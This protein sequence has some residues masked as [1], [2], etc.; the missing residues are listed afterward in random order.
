MGGQSLIQKKPT[1][2]TNGPPTTDSMLMT[3]SVSRQNTC[4]IFHSNN[5]KWLSLFVCLCVVRFQVWER[6]C[7]GGDRG[8]V[9][10]VPFFEASVLWQQ[11]GH[12][13][14]AWQSRAVLFHQWGF[15][16][17]PEGPQDDNQSV[18]ASQSQPS[19]IPQLYCST[20]QQ[21]QCSWFALCF[22]SCFWDLLCVLSFLSFH[23]NDFELVLFR[24]QFQGWFSWVRL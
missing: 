21:Q 13:G 15:R 8:G 24:M 20:P 7:D 22:L 17:L 14:E 4:Q 2:T 16:A 12:S 23:L 19:S 5:H 11:W 10:A 3:P 9:Q 6:L 1:D 18:G